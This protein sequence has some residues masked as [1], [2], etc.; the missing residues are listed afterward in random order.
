MVD[1]VSRAPI[2][3]FSYVFLLGRKNPLSSPCT[4]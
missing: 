3:R 2:F 4:A 1:I